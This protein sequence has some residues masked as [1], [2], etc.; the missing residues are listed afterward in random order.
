MLLTRKENIIPPRG[1]FANE[2][3][4]PLNLLSEEEQDD[5]PS[6]VYYACLDGNFN[7]DCDTHFGESPDRN[8]AA[9]ID[10]ADL[11]CRSMGWEMLR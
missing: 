1:L 3:G 7:Y 6:D 4:L 8:S 10:E 5:I 2:S 11:L 9:E